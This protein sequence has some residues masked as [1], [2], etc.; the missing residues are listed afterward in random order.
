MKNRKLILVLLAFISVLTWFSFELSHNLELLSN[1]SSA[2]WRQKRPNI[3]SM[4]L[5][6]VDYDDQRI[7]WKW[8]VIVQGDEVIQM[9]SLS[10]SNN[11]SWFNNYRFTIEGAY[12]AGK[13]FCFAL[14]DCSIEIDPTYFYPKMIIYGSR[15]VFVDNFKACESVSECLSK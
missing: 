14:R 3:Y 5:S 11:N 2:A 15:A 7:E 6:V 8:L 10:G 13:D 9:E 12:E 4:E 1:L